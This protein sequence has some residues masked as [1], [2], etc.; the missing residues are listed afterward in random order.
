MFLSYYLNLDSTNR[1]ISANIISIYLHLRLTISIPA[2]A[3]VSTPPPLPSS[4]LV[5]ERDLLQ[6]AEK[7]RLIFITFLF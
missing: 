1:F 7:T 6:G 2:T 5:C 4:G 3:T